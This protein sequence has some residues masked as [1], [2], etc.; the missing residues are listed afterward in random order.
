ME[1]EKERPK[2]IFEEFWIWRLEESPEFATAVGIHDYD[3]KLD[4]HSLQAFQRR[5][6]EAA[7]FLKRL[8]EEIQKGPIEESERLNYQLLAADIQ[9]Y[10]RGM[11]F[12]SYLFPINQ[13][14]GPQADFPRLISWMKTKTLEDYEKILARLKSFPAQIN[15]LTELLRKGVEDNRTMAIESIQAVPK[16][17]KLAANTPLAQSELFKPFLK[18]PAKIVMSDQERLKAEAEK[19]ITGQVGQSYLELSEF[20][21]RDYIPHVRREYGILCLQDGAAYYQ[22]CLNFH[23]T[24]SMSA[25]EIFDLG[26]KEVRRISDQMDRLREK[27]GFKGNLAD[28]KT[29]MKTSPEFHFKSAEEMFSKY[30]AVCAKIKTMLSSIFKNIPAQKYVIAPVPEDIAPGFPGAYYFSPSLDGTRP[31]TFY[32]NTYK[33]EERS[34]TEVVSLSLHEAEPGHHLQAVTAMEIKGLPSFRRFLEDRCYYQ[35]P[36]RFPLNTGYVEGW[37]LYCE[38]LG[39]EMNLYQDPYDFFGRLSHEMLRACRLVIDTGIHVFKWSRDDGIKFLQENTGMAATDVIAEIDR[40]IT[41]P[42]Q[43]C[44]YK[45]GELKI[46]EVRAKCQTKMGGKFDLKEFHSLVLS[47]GPVPL[48]IMEDATNLFIDNASKN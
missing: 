35:A 8:E 13:L 3:W 11:K 31:A 20:L 19:I 30:K 6:Q 27:V 16:Q 48:H 34:S 21:S 45:I 23:T 12:K 2:N 40:Y 41:W 18:F 10:L 28:F 36:G 26:N 1:A 38:F 4:D 14:E 32:L 5:E 24:T 29:H 9:Q 25:K 33:V 42:G 39:E 22:E 46:K 17:L 15:Q 37:G 7:G 44:A 43:A 47:L